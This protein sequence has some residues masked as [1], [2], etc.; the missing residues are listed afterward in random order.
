VLFCFRCSRGEGGAFI[1][2]LELKGLE[3]SLKVLEDSLQGLGI[4]ESVRG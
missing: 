2:Q 4:V 1:N 3:G